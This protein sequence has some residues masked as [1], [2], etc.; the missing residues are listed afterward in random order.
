[1]TYIEMTIEACGI[2]KEIANKFWYY[3]KQLGD[4]TVRIN[5]RLRT[6]AGKAKHREQEIH[7]SYYIFRE[8]ENRSEFRNIVLH[9][10]S[11]LLV[12]PKIGHGSKWKEVHRM[13]GGTAKRCHTMEAG[14]RCNSGGKC[15][16]VECDKCGEQV[17][18]GVRKYNNIIR[19]ISMGAKYPHRKCGGLYIPVEN[20]QNFNL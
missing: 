3:K 19:S 15:R 9:E 2:K 10:L 13:I 5:S 6:T 12:G 7:L 17:E 4:I 16:K 1:M 18:V 8:E 11:H 14:V 20:C